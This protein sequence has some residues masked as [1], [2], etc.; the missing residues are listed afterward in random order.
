MTLV[1]VCTEDHANYAYLMTEALKSVG[2]DATSFC[3]VKHPFD[4]GES[5]IVIDADTMLD[6]MRDADAIQVMHSDPLPLQLLKQLPK[7][8]VVVYHTGSRYR[9][10]PKTYNNMFAGMRTVIAL[11]EFHLTCDGIYIPPCIDTNK[12]QPDF[13]DHGGVFAHYPSNVEVKGSDTIKAIIPEIQFS[14]VHVSHEDNLE[15]MRACDIYVELFKLKLGAASYGSFGMTAL[16]AAALGKVVVSSYLWKDYY[17]AN[18]GELG[19]IHVKSLDDLAWTAETL[20][21]SD[22]LPLKE[23]S[24]QWAERHSFEAIGNCIKQRLWTT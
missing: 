24:R 22:L 5:S 2:V 20:R 3:T 11:A 14:P 21:N 1:S 9:Q 19:L 16:E 17:E 4:Y 18:F 23:K 12:L 8:E 15:R 10:D 13:T 6:V 7:K